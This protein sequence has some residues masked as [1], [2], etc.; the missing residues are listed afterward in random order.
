[1]VDFWGTNLRARRFVVVAG[2]ATVTLWP[3]GARDT[4]HPSAQA[5]IAQAHDEQTALIAAHK[6]GTQVEVVFS[7]G[8]G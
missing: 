5:P 1:M 2:A 7:G 6:Q 4:P 8:G 3:D